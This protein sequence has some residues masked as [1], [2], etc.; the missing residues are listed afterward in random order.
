MRHLFALIAL[1]A[2]PA[3]AMDRTVVVGDYDSVR[4]DG[5]YTVEIVTGRSPSGRM[6]GSVQALDRTLVELRG[7]TVVVRRNPNGWGGWQG[8]AVGPVVVR[9]AAPA[10][11]TVAVSG[12][13]IVVVDRMRG[14]RVQI[15]MDG[16]GRVQVGRIESD[17][18]ALDALGTGRIVAGGKV[19][20]ATLAVRGS[21][22]LDAPALSVADVVLT[23]EGTGDATLS[24]VRSAKVTALGSGLVTV[25]GRPACSVTNTG[26]GS[27]TCGAAMPA[28]ADRD[29]PLIAA[30]SPQALPRVRAGVPPRRRR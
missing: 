21:A 23:V 16:S 2:A 4:V 29:P 14:P 20:N 10:I 12:P 11:T 24:A 22:T 30:P 26:S 13:G 8:E 9:L 19:A 25:Y 5:P 27:V 6:S 15:V 28:A 17:R 18:L 3:A 7:H 1:V